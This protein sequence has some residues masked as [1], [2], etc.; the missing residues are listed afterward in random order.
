MKL[1]IQIPCLNESGTLEETL[2]ALPKELPGVETIETLIIDDGSTDNTAAVAREAGATR[3]VAF[4]ANRGLAHAFS[5]GL[6]TALDMGADIIVNTDADNQYC[7]E[8]INRLV[9]PVVSGE[10]D[11]VVGARPIEDNPNFGWLKKRLQR[12]GSSVVRWVS[13]V[14]VEDAPSGFRAFSREAARRIRVFDAYTYTLDTL[15]QAGQKGLKVISVP[16]RVNRQTRPSRLIKS[17]PA[18]IRRSL[19]TIFRIFVLYRP[20]TFFSWLAAASFLPGFLLGLRFLLFYFRGEGDG[21]VQS[22]IL[23]SILLLSG[24]LL[25]IVAILADLIAANRKLLEDLQFKIRE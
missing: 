10:A 9:A 19:L 11:M 21:H 12:L 13:G 24:V 15:I 1:V 2:R 14:E 8:D 7:G 22:L 6:Q 4:K 25:F 16:V 3:V 17:T 23:A 18:Y 20:F 5:A